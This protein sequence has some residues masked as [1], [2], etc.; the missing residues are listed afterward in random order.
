MNCPRCSSHKCQEIAEEVDI[1]VGIQRRVTGWECLSCGLAI[2][3]CPNCRMPAP[4]HAKWCID[5]ETPVFS[6]CNVCGRELIRQDEF[7]C[8]MCMF[9][10]NE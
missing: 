4:E 2:A 1:G 10:A 5:G 7:A 6:N 8:G 9:C 3:A